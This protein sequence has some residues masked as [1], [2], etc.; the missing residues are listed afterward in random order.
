MKLRDFI[1]LAHHP[2]KPAAL[3]DR[4]LTIADAQKSAKRRLPKSI[5]EYMEGGAEDE[6]SLNRNRKSYEDWRIVPQW[7]S[8][9]GPDLSIDILGGK[10]A[11]PLLL[12]PTG[13]SRLFHPDGEIATLKAAAEAGIPFGLAGLSNTRMEDVAASA[14]QARRWF[15]L[16][17]K[18]DKGFLAAMLDR[19]RSSGYETIMVNIDCRAIGHRER[20][21]RNGFTAPPSLRLRT[22]IDGMI[23]PLWSLNFVSN[24][25]IAFPNLAPD[26]P[27]GR[28]VSTPEMWRSLLSGTYEP[29]DWSDL[30]DLRNR[31][32]GPI[33]LK[34]C[35]NPKDIAIAERIGFDAVQVSNHGGRQL[36][37]MASPLDMLPEIT[38]SIRGDIDLIIDG[39]IRRGVDVVKALALGASAASIGRPHLY[40]LAAAG[41]RGVSRVLSIFEAEIRRTMFLTGCSSIAEIQERGPELLRNI[42]R[43]GE[44]SA[45]AGKDRG[46]IS[47]A[48]ISS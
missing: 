14:P 9:N 13:G 36:D 32:N 3:V 11:L 18:S 35:V 40:G 23:H 46:Q 12:S 16:E 4:W 45:P 38:N 30:E 21:Y 1:Q 31:W 29:T 24:E 28:L 47:A 26:M 42:N 15:N 20:D 17:L 27:T 48:E 8:I 39:G 44:A 7:G 22:I 41:H 5:Y 33:V 2:D 10:S 6:A 34:G 19:V 43:I 25:A 37:H